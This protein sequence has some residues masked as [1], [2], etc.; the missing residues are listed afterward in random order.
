MRK[1]IFKVI[2]ILLS[3]CIIIVGIKLYRNKNKYKSIKIIYGYGELVFTDI[4]V[5]GEKLEINVTGKELVELKKL[6]EE[7]DI[8]N[9]ENMQD[10]KIK[11]VY[12]GYYKLKFYDGST[13]VINYNSYSAQYKK[14]NNYSK[15]FDAQKIS[16]FVKELV[17]DELNTQEPNLIYSTQITI[18]PESSNKTMVITDKEIISK[19]LNE[20]K[21]VKSDM[22][23]KML[24]ESESYYRKKS[25]SE[26]G[27]IF[28]F[29]ISYNVN[30]N[31]DTS[32]KIYPHSSTLGCF[33][34]DTGN[35]KEII[36]IYGQFMNMI[37]N[38]YADYVRNTNKLFEA[39][40]ISIKHNG[41]ITDISDSE[42]EYIL[43]ELSKLK[44]SGIGYRNYEVDDDTK[45]YILLIN[46]NQI[47]LD[48]TDN[49][50]YSIVENEKIKEISMPNA[51]KD[52]IKNLVD[53]N[54]G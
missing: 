24:L 23:Y 15:I 51:F 47:I 48:D 16:Q 26:D 4:K 10:G 17:D 43:E 45:D 40:K 28:K 7:S 33:L 1:N 29:E 39:P 9:S 54:R 49:N 38:L 27:E 8:E 44:F 18:S 22:S 14:F 37:D 5:D 2:V 11:F 6:I 30:F 20:F 32:V 46:T 25:N 42:K 52:Y 41:I 34:D 3:I 21:Y 35:A 50:V 36:Q 12:P 31:D 19:L 53:K 13:M